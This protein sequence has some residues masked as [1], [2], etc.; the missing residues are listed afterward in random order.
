MPKAA[1]SKSTS[2]RSTPLRPKNGNTIKSARPSVKSERHNDAIENVKQ[3]GST[4]SQ[5]PPPA[6]QKKEESEKLA[7]AMKNEP[8][9]EE[10]VK[11][12]PK[13]VDTIRRKLLKEEHMMGESMKHEPTKDERPVKNEH[14]SCKTE[15]SD[16]A[17]SIWEE[18]SMK[19][20]RPNVKTEAAGE[21]DLSERDDS[22]Y[23]LVVAL[24]SS[25]DPT[26]TR[27]LSVPPSLTFADLHEALQIA[28]GWSDMHMHDFTVDVATKPDD[29]ARRLFHKV[30]LQLHRHPNSAGVWPEPQKEVDW[31]LCDVFEKKVWHDED[32]NPVG[33]GPG[34]GKI[35]LRYEYDMGDGW[36][37]VITLLGRAQKGL[38]GDVGCKDMRVLCLGG[39]GHP[40]AED[41]GGSGG[42]EALKRIYR[43]KRC[44]RDDKDLKDWFE[45]DCLNGDPDGLDPYQWDILDVNAELT[46]MFKPGVERPIYR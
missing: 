45:N 2:A 22:N 8:I 12:E 26:V 20:E 30:V 19:M 21:E 17:A 23:L 16:E 39:E 41:I 9:G 14:H 38:H 13:E 27:F 42:W 3:E 43:K 37:H 28:F 44:N 24:V 29:N 11:R 6:T 31:R 1:K 5:S 35:T 15:P 34:E 25:K 36:M 10:A 32:G 46:E 4:A 18:N 7:D 33:T 40:C